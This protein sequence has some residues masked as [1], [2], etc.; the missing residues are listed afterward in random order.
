MDELRF[1]LLPEMAK[2]EE[3]D[4]EAEEN[5]SAEG[6]SGDMVNEFQ[7]VA[8]LLVVRFGMATTRTV[9]HHATRLSTL[10]LA[11]LTAHLVVA[12]LNPAAASQGLY[13][14]DLLT[15]NITTSFLQ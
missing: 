14:G 15:R 4:D 6:T 9:N 8:P 5:E 10:F 13:T 1:V 11:T 7:V 12:Q 2:G 3:P